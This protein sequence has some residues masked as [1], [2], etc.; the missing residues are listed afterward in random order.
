MRLVGERKHRIVLLLAVVVVAADDGHGQV[1]IVGRSH[2]LT[3]D[4]ERCGVT[5]G[6]LCVRADVT[7]THRGGVVL[8]LRSGG[9][10]VGVDEQQV[11]SRS[12]SIDQTVDIVNLTAGQ[13]EAEVVVACLGNGG[14]VGR[15]V[16]LRSNIA[17]GL[18]GGPV[19]AVGRNHHLYL[20]GRRT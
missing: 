12:R 14:R 10:N 18:D 2:F 6:S 4:I 11:V 1:N 19:R 15:P 8:V 13:L 17:D 7:N 9:R 3:V 20:T 16:I 5:A